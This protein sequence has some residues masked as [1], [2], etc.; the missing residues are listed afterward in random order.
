MST[1]ATV[2]YDPDSKAHLFEVRPLDETV[3]LAY[4]ELMN[5][6]KCSMTK[7]IDGEVGV[8]VCI[9]SEVMDRLAVA[10]CRHRKLQREVGGPVG[11]EYGG[12]DCEYE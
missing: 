6:K 10:W 5:P 12:P 4:I 11:K 8:T 7:D 2:F 9:N 1:K 3:V